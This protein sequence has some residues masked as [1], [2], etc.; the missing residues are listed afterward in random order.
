MYCLVFESSSDNSVGFPPTQ[1]NESGDTLG[2]GPHAAH[3]DPV[4]Q[5]HGLLV[6][7]A[8]AALPLAPAPA[9]LLAFEDELAFIE[10]EVLEGA[11]GALGLEEGDEG[12]LVGVADGGGGVLRPDDA[13][14]H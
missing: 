5:L 10:G 14:E 3:L 9:L 1:T 13:V 12:F 4:E 2:E 7:L 11:V 6:G 8:D